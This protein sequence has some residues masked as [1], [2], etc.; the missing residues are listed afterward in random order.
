MQ[1]LE[2]TMPFGKSEDLPFDLYVMDGEGHHE[3]GVKDAIN[4]EWLDFRNKGI[5]GS[6]VAAIMGISKY[7][8]PVEVWMEKRGLKEPADLSDKEA[9]EWGNRLESI[10]RDKFAET[11]PELM[12]MEL[13]ASLVSRERPWAHANLDGCVKNG[14]GE[15]GVLEIKTVGKNREKDWADGVPD[16]YLT[17]VTHYL[18]VTGW[19]YA[20]VAALIGGQHY[21][22]FKVMRDEDDVAMVESAV[23]TFWNDCVVGG[24]LPQIV[25]GSTESGALLDL[26][27]AESSEYVQPENANHFDTLVHDYQEAK[28]CEKKY[29][30]QAKRIANDIRA[31]VGSAKGAV[32]DV[33]K[34]TWVKSASTRFDSKRFAAEHP[35]MAQGYMVSSLADRGLRVSEVKR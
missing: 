10:V 4:A 8:T 9:V 24:A 6:D 30:E 17:Q 25:G 11:H 18:S 33:Y 15:W 7:R 31:V 3:L 1:V 27:G 16:Y 29:A 22:E 20:W 35:D 14:D 28:A 13:P 19:K 21:V 12:V 34:V 5:G 26:F 23:D 32:S 2:Q